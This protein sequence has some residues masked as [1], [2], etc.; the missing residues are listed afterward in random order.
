MRK[1][2]LFLGI[3]IL[4]LG[5]C[6]GVGSATL[7][8]IIDDNSIIYEDE[9]GVDILVIDHNAGVTIAN[10]TTGNTYTTMTITSTL[11]A[12]SLTAG[13][14]VTPGGIACAKQLYLG[15]D[16]DMS[17]SGTGVYDITL[18]TNVAEALSITDGTNIIVF[19][20]AATRMVT[21][22]P[23]LT[24]T[25][26]IISDSTTDTSSGT[27]GAIQTDGGIGIAKN[28]WVAVNTRLVGTVTCDAV[29]SID[30]TT[31]ATGSTDGS[32]HTDGGVGI[33]KKLY[34]VGA[35]DFASTLQLDGALTVS[36]DAG[37]VDVKIYGNTT[38]YYVLFDADANSN[39]TWY[40]GANTK[41]LDV[42]LY[43][44]TTGCGV[45]WDP[46]GDSND[47]VLSVGATGGSKGVDLVLYG[48]TDTNFVTWDQSIDTLLVADDTY[49]SLGTTQT[50]AV[51]HVTM[52]W[53]ETTT[54]VGLMQF[55]SSSAPMV[56]NTNPG[57]TAQPII[58]INV[59]HSAGAGDAVW[60]TGVRS[61]MI[62]SGDGDSGTKLAPI[63]ASIL[64]DE[65]A[66]S[67]AYTIRAT[68]TH[69]GTDT[70]SGAAAVVNADLYLE[71]GN[72][73]AS[74]TLQ[75]AIFT[76]R[77]EGAVTV[78]CTSEN[79]NVVLI[80]NLGNIAGLNSL[81]KLVSGGTDDPAAII[82][83]EGVGDD[84]FI[85]FDA[86]TDCVAD[87]GATGAN[88]T[89]KIKCNHN[90]TTFYLAGFADF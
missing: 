13:S 4:T 51:T 66:I 81:L 46:S 72:F 24:V 17:V 64:L 25:G 3:L 76:L 30:D 82:Q 84:G 28:L 9:A 42:T 8:T 7:H 6:V 31:E 37:G 49:F 69:D 67:S 63:H 68:L 59:T 90:G 45:F 19:R 29:V 60:L 38:G 33:A 26:A 89:Y 41:G 32:L 58:D 5:L 87:T 1:I 85:H 14:I 75:T 74:Q 86:G 12:S 61:A 56:Y 47:G 34:V 44:I 21:I 78:T 83:V 88:A 20:T 39:G 22:T 43:S 53:D 77:A 62:I 65:A 27:T 11:D 57:A 54:G 2:L 55:G 52:E 79:F 16:L 15:D 48:D 36:A 18:R 50:T 70:I 23:A 73:T 35:V 40:F 10:Y 71:S 80:K